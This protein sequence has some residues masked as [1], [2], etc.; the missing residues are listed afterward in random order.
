MTVNYLILGFT[1]LFIAGT[2]FYYKYTVKKGTE[3]RYKPL[4]LLVVILLFLL[5][6]YG[7]IV[8]K[9]YN[10]ILPFIG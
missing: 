3:F 9:P 6:L 7:I 1:S 4:T 8:G 2:F 5:S 10:E